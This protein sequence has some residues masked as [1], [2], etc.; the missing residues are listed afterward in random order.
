MKEQKDSFVLEKSSVRDN[1]WALKG[2]RMPVLPLLLIFAMA[3]LSAYASMNI[4]LFTGS[5]VDANGDVPT[6]QL[7][8]FAITYLLVGAAA[9][10]TVIFSA[11]ASEKINLGLRV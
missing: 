5:M 1:L 6:R 4:S 11:F 3:M 9:A 8:S 2:T 10:G 7:V